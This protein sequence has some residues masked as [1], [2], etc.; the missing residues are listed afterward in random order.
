MTKAVPLKNIVSN[1]RLAQAR[2]SNATGSVVTSAG[3]SIELTWTD[4]VI[5][6][7]LESRVTL[8]RYSVGVGDGLAKRRN[9]GDLVS[10]DNGNEISRIR[11]KGDKIRKL[12]KRRV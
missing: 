4:K 7:R 10:A 3:S 8:H 12:A 9:L 1:S 6:L 5:D 2:C 11:I